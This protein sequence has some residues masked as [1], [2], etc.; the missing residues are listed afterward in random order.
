M[1]TNNFP[2]TIRFFGPSIN[3][4]GVPIC[5]AG[6]VLAAFNR[7]V[8]RAH[9]ISRHKKKALASLTQD[10]R[11]R[12]SL[13]I[14]EINQPPRTF[15]LDWFARGNQYFLLEETEKLLMLLRKAL[16]LYTHAHIKTNPATLA[17][18]LALAIFNDF[19]EIASR[20]G[21]TGNIQQIGIDIPDYEP[22][23]IDEPVQAYVE[24]LRGKRY[25]LDFRDLRGLVQAPR[26]LER[27]LFLLKA[28]QPRMIKVSARDERAFRSILA[29][30]LDVLSHFP[31]PILQPYFTF[32]GKPRLRIGD[33]P[34]EFTEFVLGWPYVPIKYL[35]DSGKE[36]ILKVELESEVVKV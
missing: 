31:H 33:D 25:E 15:Y 7:M 23:I 18:R 4:R 32:H 36:K 35:D 5:E 19:W 24:S 28:N 6:A 22:I 1:N 13:Q 2:L 21:K 11:L 12:L 30:V 9:M 8:Y 16:L 3:P 17:E 14:A 20:I 27:N 29:A 10:D 26:T 34:D